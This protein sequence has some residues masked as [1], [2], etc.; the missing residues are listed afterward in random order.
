ML[1]ATQVINLLTQSELSVVLSNKLLQ[2][3]TFMV[4]PTQTLFVSGLGRIDYV[5]VNQW[6]SQANICMYVKKI[7]SLCIYDLVLCKS[8]VLIQYSILSS[9]LLEAHYTLIPWQT[10]SIKHHLTFS[11]KHP[12]MLQLM[13]EVVCTNIHHCL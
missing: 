5:E 2:P 7:M 9:G 3:R 8:Y 10:C 13:R 12:A 1:F 4:K 11:E 6:N